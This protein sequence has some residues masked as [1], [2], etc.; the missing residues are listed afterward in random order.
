MINI[1]EG[2]VFA[3]TDEKISVLVAVYNE[4]K[5]LNQCIQSVVDQNYK[6]WELI[7]ID[8]GSTDNSLAIAQ[9]WVDKDKRIKLYQQ[10]HLGVCAA[11]NESI[12][13][14]TGDY[15][16]FL[17]ADDFLTPECLEV[18]YQ[19]LKK[20]D[21][22]IAV[23]NYYELNNGY[24][25][26]HVTDRK[27]FT[28]KYDVKSWFSLMERPDNS[29]KIVWVI[30][31][32][33]LY[34]KELFKNIVFPEDKLIDDSY[35][36]WKI[37]LQARSILYCNIE[38]YCYRGSNNTLSRN[39]HKHTADDIEERYAIMAAIG[40]PLDRVRKS[41]LWSLNQAK[42][43]SLADGDYAHYKEACYKL[44]IINK[45]S[46]PNNNNQ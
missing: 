13:L 40:F 1:N 9:N 12:R 28:K 25:Y 16:Y 34:K 23:S 44:D 36:A 20:Y 33:K 41:Y 26:F 45:Y 2:R 19:N 22:D 8:D 37:Y 42:E 17:D 21:V 35:M 14:A 6:N 10:K 15:Y 30:L 32:A 46:K 31:C 7:L 3:M 4:E 11:R 24:F 18:L 38:S 39:N 29:Y 43:K 27:F 5:Y